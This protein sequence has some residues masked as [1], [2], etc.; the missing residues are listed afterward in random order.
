MKRDFMFAAVGW[1]RGLSDVAQ[2]EISKRFPSLP[3][4]KISSEAGYYFILRNAK[5]PSP[6]EAR[7]TLRTLQ[8]KAR[9]LRDAMEHA[10]YPLRHE[11]YLAAALQTLPLDLDDL[12]VALLHLEKVCS[13]AITS[14]PEGRRRSPKERLVRALAS[15][16]QNVGETLDGKPKGAFCR[17]VEIVLR[18]F[19]EKPSDVRKLVQPI[20][21]ELE[22]SKKKSGAFSKVS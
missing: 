1:H 14:I 2:K 17:V 12:Q 22:N 6:E 16:F 15:I 13:K 9:A 5:H 8:G 21:R 19:G 10:P 18:D 7:D 11:I 3:I 4:D 20:V